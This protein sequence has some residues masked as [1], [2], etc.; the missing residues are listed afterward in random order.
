MQPSEQSQKPLFW[1]ILINLGNNLLNCRKLAFLMCFLDTCGSLSKLT[2]SGSLFSVCCF[3]ESQTFGTVPE[4]QTLGT[5]PEVP[6]VP[7]ASC[8]PFARFFVVDFWGNS[9]SL[10][11]TKKGTP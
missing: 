3:P 1:V 7:E 6:K 8:A 11:L 4:V 9:K 2:Q 10:R 5:V